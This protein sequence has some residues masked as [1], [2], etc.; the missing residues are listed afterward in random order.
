MDALLEAYNQDRLI[1]FVGA[2]LSRSL[3]LP[4]WKDLIDHIAKELHYDPDV[5]R[6][7]GEP[8]ALA[9]Y[10]RL[11]KGEIGPLRSWMDR[12]WHKP[13]IDISKSRAHEL[14]AKSKLDLIYTTNY[15][16]WLEK[17]FDFYGARYARIASVADMVSAP[18]GVPNIIK[19][20]GD[21]DHDPSIVLDETSYFERLNFES[22]LDIRFR[23]DVLG[24]SVLFIGYS[25][26]DPNVRY[27]F[28]RLAK[29]WKESGRSA[30]QPPSFIFSSQPNPI[31]ETILNQWNIKMISS[32]A[33]EPGLALVEFLESIFSQVV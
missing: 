12:E 28:Y 13:D 8:L 11:I 7:L 26:S 17:S 20:H 1:L 31:Q 27:L 14:I 18:K 30:A 24:R 9:E 5:Y 2:G 32:N 15:D 3:G 21:F 25:I 19:F 29:I 4:L 22:P 10:Y 6:T 33:G 16:R 23:A